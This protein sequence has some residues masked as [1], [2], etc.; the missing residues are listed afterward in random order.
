MQSLGAAEKADVPGSGT[1]KLEMETNSREGSGAKASTCQHICSWRM[2]LCILLQFSIVTLSLPKSTFNM[3]FVCSTSRRQEVL[4][5]MNKSG[6]SA[7]DGQLRGNSSLDHDISHASQVMTDLNWNSETKGLIL[8]S[9]MMP[10]FVGPMLSDVI[11]LKLGNAFVF[12]AIFLI[13]GTITFVSPLLARIS[14]SLV[15]AA[16]IVLGLTTDANM[17]IIGEV[18]PHWTPVSE[19]ITATFIVFAGYSFGPTISVLINGFLCSIPI[20]NGWPFIFY[21]SGL[22]YFLYAAAWNVLGSEWP[23]THRFVSASE[24][25]HILSTRV[26]LASGTTRKKPEKPPYLSMFR[27]SAVLAFYFLYSCHRWGASVILIMSPVYFNS[28]LGFSAEQT[29][30][31]FSCV[32]CMRLGGSLMWT[33]LGNALINKKIVSYSVAKKL[34]LCIA[35]GGASFAHLAV[36]FFDHD[37]RWMSVGCMMIGQILQS[38]VGHLSSVPQDLAPRYAGTL[39]GTAASVSLLAALTAPLVVS[40]LTPQGVYK[41]WRVVWILLSAVYLS[42]SIVFLIFGKTKVQAWAAITPDQEADRDHINGGSPD[43][44]A[45]KSLLKDESESRHRSISDSKE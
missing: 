24:K 25:S 30:V 21:V 19:R 28:V 35:F 43:K 7:A 11:R 23:E 5:G 12:N 41:E 16:Q 15:I 31:V 45:D 1:M 26:Q 22:A 33:V 10:A 8:S 38:A 6:D 36:A 37:T 18:L 20:D 42:G 32:A 4:H 3:A 39:Q 27:S 9:L 14:P 13:A 44:D 29:G 2:L 40:A 17:P 34:C